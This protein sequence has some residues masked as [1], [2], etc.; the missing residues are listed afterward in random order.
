MAREATAKAERDARVRIQ[1]AITAEQAAAAVAA[2][3]SGDALRDP[4]ARGVSSRVGGGACGQHGGGAGADPRRSPSLDRSPGGR[5]H[6]GAGREDGG[7]T[8]RRDWDWRERE[9]RRSADTEHGRG[10][11]ERERDDHRE[12]DRF[13]SVSRSNA[14]NMRSPRRMGWEGEGVAAGRGALRVAAG[15]TKGRQTT[16]EGGEEREGQPSSRMESTT[17]NPLGLGACS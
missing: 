13:Y 11:W 1:A 14:D 17:P 15:W 10:R 9:R 5:R 6:N 12:P 16:Q 4:R 7:G 2:A 8:D 3:Q